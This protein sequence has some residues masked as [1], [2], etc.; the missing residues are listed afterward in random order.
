MNCKILGRSKILKNS[1]F[2]VDFGL[3]FGVIGPN[4]FDNAAD[5]VIIVNRERYR[6]MIINFFW[7][8]LNGLDT[9]DIWLALC[10][11]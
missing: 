10:C 5:N 1:L 3:D 6:S 7:A 8:E 4:L 2:G 11:T 9:N